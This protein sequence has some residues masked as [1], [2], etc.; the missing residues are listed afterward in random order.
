MTCSSLAPLRQNSSPTYWMLLS[1]CQLTAFAGIVPSELTRCKAQ[2]GQGRLWP[3]AYEAD[4]SPHGSQ[5]SGAYRYAGH[6]HS[7]IARTGAVSEVAAGHEGHACVE[8]VH[9]GEADQIIGH[10]STYLASLGC[11]ILDHEAASDRTERLL[12]LGEV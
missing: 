7:L 2:R 1:S 12:H 10:G 4:A 5:R 6:A 11:P 8:G 3:Y 9:D